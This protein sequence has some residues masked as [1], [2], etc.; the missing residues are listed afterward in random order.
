RVNVWDFG[1]QEIYHQTHQ[2]FLT[3]RSL[4]ALVVD[5]RRE[6]ANFYY[7]LEVV[8][9]LS[10]NSPVIIIKNEKQGRQCQVNDR[11]LQRDFPNIRAILR[12]NLKTNRGLDAIKAAIQ[13]HISH[14]PHVGD[15]LPKYWVRIRSALENY[16]QHCNYISLEKYF[17]LCQQF[18]FTDKTNMLRASRYLH[19]LGICLHFQKD[20][21]LKKTVILKPDWATT[22]VYKV[23]DTPKVRESKGRFTRDDLRE[24]WQDSQYSEMQGELLQLMK[25]FKLCYEIPGLNNTF[26][27]PHLL[28][29]EQPE[30]DWDAADNLILRYEYE[31]MPKG[32]LTQFIVEMHKLIERQVL[33][34]KTGV[35][36]T[37]GS[38]RVEVLE[39]YRPHKGEI[40]VTAS[41]PNKK[42]LLERV[43]HELWKIHESYEELDY[44]ELIPCNCSRCKGDS[45][46]DSYSYELLQKYL[47]DGRYNIECRR[48]YEDVDVRRLMDKVIKLYPEYLEL[49][50]HSIINSLPASARRLDRARAKRISYLD[51]IE[52]YSDRPKKEIFISYAWGGDGEAMADKIEA[53]C[54]NCNL[55]LIRDKRDLGFKGLIQDFMRRIGRGKA[56]ILIISEKYLKSE[57]CMFELLEVSKNGSFLDRI[58]PIVLPDANIYKP[59]QR[60]RFV[61]HWEAQIKA[62]E[63]AMQ[64]VSPANMQGF[65]DDIDLY[66]EIRGAIAELTNTLKDM[67]TLTAE[68]HQDSNF[69]G[70]IEAIEKQL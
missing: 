58:F 46:P 30:Y 65:R 33:V 24:I 43:R 49:N 53:I 14:L 59:I 8:K 63:E 37:D 31:F 51:H 7:W 64:T 54:Q 66:T 67:N 21:L 35:V 23:C 47:H 55:P 2:F 5:E 10:G 27:A 56:V 41:G 48:S 13:Q 19:D 62:L 1:G 68:I 29:L 44:S 3:E 12:T 38:A 57:N 61:Q 34:W 26:I 52:T 25:Q 45:K 60:I 9:L 11:Q 22:A 17:D 20:D 4:Y 18:G 39:F 16:A 36:L 40:R 69:E 50:E 70:L 6:S 15:P 32:M 42:L 28:P